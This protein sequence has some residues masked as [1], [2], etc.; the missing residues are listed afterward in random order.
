MTSGSTI[1]RF[2]EDIELTV[3]TVLPI[4]RFLSDS[5]RLGRLGHGGTLYLVAQRE[6]RLLLVAVL[7]QPER[8]RIKKGDRRPDGWYAPANVVPVT[9]I[10]AL[11]DVLG[12]SRLE[13]AMAV[14]PGPEAELRALFDDEDD[15]VFAKDGERTP[16]VDVIEELLVIWRRTRSV[17]I[18]DL[19][20]HVTRRLPR[21]DRPLRDD[22]D[23]GRGEQRWMEA[24]SDERA[25]AMPQLLQNF[26]CASHEAL[27][28]APDDPRIA[29]T[30]ARHVLSGNR[31]VARIIKR[32]RDATAW[33]ESLIVSEL[34]P[35]RYPGIHDAYA[36][37]TTQ[38]ASKP[39]TAAELARVQ[40]IA[41]APDAAELTLIDAIAEHAADDEPY[42]IYSDWLLERG[43][44]RGEYIAL[45]CQKRR[46]KLSPA[47]VRRLAA[48]EA[49]PFL[50]GA[51]DDIATSWRRERPRGIDRA[52][53]VYGSTPN[54]A[55]RE[56]ALHPLA[57]ALEQ[58]TFIT[59]PGP[60]RVAGIAALAR[61]APR[62]RRIDGVTA[63]VGNALVK[64]LDA[65]WKRDGE[66]VVRR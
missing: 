22:R 8:S 49:I 48:L 37:A 6:N 40:A 38:P 55:W 4:D 66:A 13:L 18:A 43:H 42:L 30:L 11:R 1:A 2:T 24:W 12:I 51:L 39:L 65:R 28:E 31:D 19:I 14:L 10:T 35:E 26:E 29:R 7:E 62:L 57:R 47:L 36:F 61:A 54:L 63:G 23:R 9:D 58:I 32:S 44:P 59:E 60:Q 56:V 3:G 21:F 17:E 25:E 5:H 20:E 16:L 64:A 52:L 33:Q 41:H 34:D 53:D 50:F 45:A 27:A 46:G 15:P